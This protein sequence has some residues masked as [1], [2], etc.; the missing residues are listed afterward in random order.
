MVKGFPDV[1]P[2]EFPGMPPD[3]DIEFLIEILPGTGPITTREKA[4]SSAGFR[5]I[6]SAGICATDKALQL[7]LSSRVAAAFVQSHATANVT[8]GS[9]FSVHRY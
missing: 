2:E 4:S 1:F 7:F 8:T 6:S 9:A 5:P 3:R